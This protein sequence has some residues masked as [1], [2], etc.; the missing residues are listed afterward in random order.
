MAESVSPVP[1]PQ[2]SAIALPPQSL[3]GSIIA[4]ATCR[5]SDWQR[6]WRGNAGRGK[7]VAAGGPARLI[8]ALGSTAVFKQSDSLD[9]E[10]GMV[11]RTQAIRQMPSKFDTL[12][13]SSTAP[14]PHLASL[15]SLEGYCDVDVDT[16]SFRRL[17]GDSQKCFNGPPAWSEAQIEEARETVMFHF[18]KGL[19]AHRWLKFKIRR[20]EFVRRMDKLI[21][22][23]SE[24]T[25]PSASAF[26]ILRAS[27]KMR[28]MEDENLANII[29]EMMFQHDGT[30]SKKMIF[31]RTIGKD[32]TITSLLDGLR[33]TREEFKKISGSGQPPQ[34]FYTHIATGMVAVA[35]ILGIEPTT[36]GTVNTDNDNPYL[37]PFTSLA[38][39]LE[40]F[41]PE[42]PEELRSNTLA[43]C[44]KRIE[45][46]GVLDA[47]GLPGF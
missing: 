25:D 21:G 4:V 16:E 27:G 47:P 1:A 34:L 40:E 41:L 38:R 9:G 26:G 20:E 10:S 18:S 28:S 23:L 17:I 30:V 13:K 6:D 12:A 42:T 11:K 14:P 32:S 31:E 43:A 39:A 29:V 36:R 15:L 24:K 33:I 2:L 22:I 37:T 8:M 35:K 46:S 19:G 5:R 45:R 7:Q 44:V 3:S